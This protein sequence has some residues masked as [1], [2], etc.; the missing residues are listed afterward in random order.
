MTMSR[1]LYWIADVEVS[2]ASYRDMR[3]GR[4][5]CIQADRQDYIM[6][7]RISPAEADPRISNT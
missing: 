6:N 4:F 7:K 3:F 1:L 2:G 5:N